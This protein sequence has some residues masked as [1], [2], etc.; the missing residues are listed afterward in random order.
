MVVFL[1]IISS[2]EDKLTKHERMTIMFEDKIPSRPMKPEIYP[3]DPLKRPI[4]PDKPK[5]NE[6][7]TIPN[8]EPIVNQLGEH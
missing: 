3:P 5:E 8:A 2:I 1:C 7:D 4:I 6:P